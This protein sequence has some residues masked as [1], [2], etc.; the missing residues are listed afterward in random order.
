MLKLTATINCLPSSNTLETAIIGIYNHYYQEFDHKVYL[1][2]YY[3]HP[4]YHGMINL[5]YHNLIYYKF[6]Y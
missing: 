6:S 3:L 1:F 2:S 4:E 5:V